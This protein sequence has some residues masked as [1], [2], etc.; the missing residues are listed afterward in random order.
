MK[1]IDAFF[2]RA[3]GKIKPVD[4]DGILKL[5]VECSVYFNDHKST[6]EALALKLTHLIDAI[7]PRNKSPSYEN[8]VWALSLISSA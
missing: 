6:L 5:A 3:A 2:E 4:L 1:G 7:Y 8:Y